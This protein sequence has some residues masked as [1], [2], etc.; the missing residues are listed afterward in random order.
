MGRMS[1]RSGLDLMRRAL[2]HELGVA[3]T[4]NRLLLMSSSQHHLC[5]DPTAFDLEFG[6]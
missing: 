5:S 1:P 2:A 3:I 4:I 6:R